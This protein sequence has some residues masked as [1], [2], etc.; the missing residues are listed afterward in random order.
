[1]AG[2]SKKGTK[3]QYINHQS[4]AGNSEARDVV[5]EVVN[6]PKDGVRFATPP[7]EKRI[8]A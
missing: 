4:R 2:D 8:Q 6:K 7:T 3:G 5:C 1:M